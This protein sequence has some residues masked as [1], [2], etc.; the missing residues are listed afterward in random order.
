MKSFT[1]KAVFRRYQGDPDFFNRIY[2][3]YGSEFFE[4]NDT[5]IKVMDF[6]D[7]NI[8]YYKCINGEFTELNN[9]NEPRSCPFC[10]SEAEKI[11]HKGLKGIHCS[12]PSCIAFDITPCFSSYK[13]AIKQWNK[14]SCLD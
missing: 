3:T 6:N 2:R 13:K 1:C 9:E 14:R 12:N 10:G 7:F 5:V 8:K 11:K 4:G